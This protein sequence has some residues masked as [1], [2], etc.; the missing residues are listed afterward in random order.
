MVGGLLGYLPFSLEDLGTSAAAIFRQQVALGLWA[1]HGLPKDA[2]IGLNDTGAITYFSGRRT[3]DVV[4]LTTA[5][6]ARYWA[7]GPG[8]RFEHYERLGRARLPSHFI[9][10]PEWF[11]LDE[12]LGE[13][14]TERYVPGASILGGDRMVA[15][16]ANYDLLGS[17]EAPTPSLLEGRTLVDRLDVADLE[18]EAEHGY[19]LFSTTQRQ[20]QLYRSGDRLDGGRSERT[21]ER[22]QLTVAA[23]G[24]LV[25]RVAADA[26]TTLRVRI[27]D[28]EQALE[29]PASA[30]YE[31]EMV[32]PGGIA[33]GMKSIS[34]ESG[35]GS[36]TSMHFFA[37]GPPG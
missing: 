22:F 33:A 17:A 16:V 21:M 25:L 35:G 32:V 8:S 20:N 2:R 30:W 1:E 10:Y 13:H 5:S 12:L 26:A 11:A 4:G 7:A 31:A 24:A 34:I 14:L 28:R 19:Q 15:Y 36:F 6:E 3:F 37:L 29:V 9:V 27:G 23:G 18:S